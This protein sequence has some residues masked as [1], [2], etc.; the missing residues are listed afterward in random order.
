MG[1]R[2]GRQVRD[3]IGSIPNRLDRKGRERL[4]I[5]FIPH[6]NDRVF[7]VHMNWHMIGFIAG[8]IVLSIFLSFYGYYVHREKAIEIEK[9]QELYGINY[10][11]AYNID[12]QASLLVKKQRQL[13]ENLEEIARLTNF[14]ST[15]LD[16]LPTSVSSREFGEQSLKKEV[17]SRLAANTDYLHSTYVVAGLNSATNEDLFLLESLRFTVEKGYSVYNRMPLGRPIRAGYRDTSDYGIRVDPVSGAQMEFHSGLDMAGARGTPVEATAEGEVVT[18]M[19]W[20][21][22]YGNAVVIKHGY[23]FQTLYGHMERIAVRSGQRVVPGTV[24]GFMGSTGRVTGVHLH[25][26]VW[27]GPSARTDPKPFVCAKDLSTARCRAFHAN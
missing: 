9:Q 6:G 17:I 26:E 22:G 25:Y 14:S 5:M 27:N 4:T 23:G 2:I 10:T 15:S 1:K 3:G 8:S 11:A 19:N 7:T 16:L 18:V 24:V 12:K 13:R 21:A 20:D